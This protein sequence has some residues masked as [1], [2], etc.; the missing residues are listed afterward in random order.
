MSIGN[1]STRRKLS[2]VFVAMMFI[3]TQSLFAVG[4]GTIKAK[5]L[6]K[7]TGDVLI[8][9]NVVILNTSLGGSADIDGL[10]TIY[11]IPTGERTIKVSYIGY[12]DIT[13]Q[14]TIAEDKILE[15]EFRMSPHAIEGEVVVVTAQARGQNEAINQQ[16]AAKSMVNVVSAEKMKEL[17]DA[18]I[19]ESIGR[20]PGASLQRDAG[21]AN[22]VVVRGLSPKYNNVTIEGVPM[23]S[24]YYGDRG[25]DL[26]LIGDDLVKGVEVSKTLR[27]D[28]DADALG[29][30]VNLTLKTAQ[31]GLHFD[32]RGNGGYTKLDNSY[33]NYKFAGTVSD[34]F[35][36]NKF[37]VLLQGNIEEKQ[38]PSNQFN[39]AYAQPQGGKLAN[40]DTVN[41]LS[42]QSATLRQT[43][44]KR[45]RYGASVILDYA[46][47]LVDV[48]FYTVY[49]QKKD[50]TLTR[51]NQQTFS[52]SQYFSQIFA[53]NTKTEQR[54]HSLQFLF[55][56]G[57]TE[58]P[59]S[60]SYTRGDVRSPNAQQ[61]DIY[62]FEG[63][64]YVP[65]KDIATHFTQPSV[66]MN[67]MGVQQPANSLLQEPW[68]T[69]TTLTD[70]SYDVKADWKVP[71]K[72]SDNLSG[73]LTLGGKYHSVDRINDRDQYGL[74]IQYG[75]GKGARL[76][77]IAY[78][79]ATYPGFSTDP[80]LQTGILARNFTDPNYTGGNI[81]GYAI[82]PQYNV[83]QLLDINNYFYANHGPESMLNGKSINEYLLSGVNSYNQDYTDKEHTAAGYIMG[84]FNIGTNLTIIPG[85]RWQEEKTDISAY[86]ILVDGLSPI[87]YTVKPVLSESKS[88][89]PNWYPSVNIKYKATENIQ[90]LAAA[91]RSVSLPSFIDI[92][93][94]L[95]F[96]SGTP[97]I[98]GGNPLLKPSTATNFDLGVSVFN[99]NIGLFTVNGFYKEISNLIYTMN[100]YYP[101]LT[102][103]VIGGPADIR[104]RLPAPAYYDTVWGKTISPQITNLSTN[105]AMN[106]PEKAFL[107]GIEL[108]WQTHMWYLPWV[109][110]GIVL[111]LN[112]SFMSSE[113]LYPY[114]KTVKTGG[115][116]LKPINSLVYLTRSG[117]LQDQP[118]AIYNAIVG[119]DYK[120][121]SS[122]FSFRYQQVTLTGLDTQ[123]GVRDAYYDNVLLVD[124]SVK[125]QIL[126]NLS[127]FADVTNVNSHIDNYYLNYYNGNDGTSGKLPTS[128]QTYGMNAQLGVSFNY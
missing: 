102:S 124:I 59:I 7:V 117:Q 40:G 97:Q 57:K 33:K 42:T 45:I 114:F 90:I 12:Q 19:A 72:M 99:N 63:T 109:L 4:S 62:G 66:L 13:L 65:I 8:G 110:S 111:D 35:F 120:G 89:N 46:S 74:Y 81:L 54:T 80:S 17:P 69:T 49:D 123:Y 68:M 60:L 76:D 85:V 31:E 43:N 79:T 48:K 18:N 11:G 73:V 14:V 47:D 15:Q 58:L 71:F 27:P 125:Q 105:I 107:R 37:G 78:L 93:P 39:A 10:V 67:Y 53:S 36:D 25:I 22:A 9:A 103:P 113:Q 104:N 5:V 56:L 28:M 86:H 38:L 16:L 64:G 6:D 92:S 94:A 34:R 83:S 128:A 52:N 115:T 24:T 20:L 116:S 127:I 1:S 95:T 61:I 77:L 101:F 30:T 91:Y 70:Q 87:G 23:V 96:G 26:S 44:T 108:S 55:K 121:F 118:K 100:N 50:S 82:G 41:N 21:E 32:L 98:A 84:E 88:D 3:M 51:S 106:N 126:T 29:G 2:C 122:R 75:Q 119:W 112:A